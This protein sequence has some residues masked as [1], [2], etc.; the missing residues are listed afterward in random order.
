MTPQEFVTPCEKNAPLKHR[1]YERVQK[2]R[3]LQSKQK[4]KETFGSDE[5]QENPV[6]HAFG[7]MV[8][9]TWFDSD[10]YTRTFALKPRSFF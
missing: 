8:L 6:L 1:A 3:K 9:K 4:V 7:E 10:S 5:G 2:S